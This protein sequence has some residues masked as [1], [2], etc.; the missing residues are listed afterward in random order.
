MSPSPAP[1]LVT[2]HLWGVRTREVPWAASRMLV[3]RA[4]LRPARIPGLRFAR[5][6]GTGHGDSFTPSDA[7]PRHWALVASWESFADADRFERHPLSRAW[8]AHSQETLRLRLRPL[9]ATG[10]WSRTEPFG[11]AR[12]GAGAPGPAAVL[13]RARLVARR[14]AQ[15]WQAV[16]PVAAALRGAPG[17]RFA[18]GI[19]EAPVGLQATFSV[20]DD[21]AAATAFAYRT[22]EHRQVITRT[23]QAGWYAEQLFARFAVIDSEGSLDGREPF[24]EGPASARAAASVPAETAA[25]RTGS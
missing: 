7:D 13:T 18:R 22:P 25:S 24:G 21:L 3:H 17:L 19:G 16:P 1:E 14:A 8:A 20:W 9:S 4:R 12:A 2:F 6:L 15:F 11:G 5:L 23:A 10:R